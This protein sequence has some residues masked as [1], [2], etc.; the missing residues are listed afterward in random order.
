MAESDGSQG[1]PGWRAVGNT[2]GERWRL[3]KAGCGH[4]RQAVCELRRHALGFEL[5]LIVD[6]SDLRNS[7]L[8]PEG[9]D[10]L[11][12]VEEWKAAM[13]ERGWS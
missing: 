8:L 7:R 10:V 9:Y 2:P 1:R 6:G 11:S 3:H 4:H 13:V 12:V 5:R